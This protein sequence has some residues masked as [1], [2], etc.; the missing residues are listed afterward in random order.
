MIKETV[1]LVDKSTSGGTVKN[2]IW[3]NKELAEELH[4]PIITKFEERI[5]HSSFIENI[6]GLD[7]GIMQ[8][9]SKFDE[10]FRFYYVLSTFIAIMHGSF[11]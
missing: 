7:I 3:S 9:I 1:P 11:L 5:L 8:F 6:W 2:E 10:G 4:K